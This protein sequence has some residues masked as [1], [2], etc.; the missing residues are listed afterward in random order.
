MDDTRIAGPRDQAALDPR[1]GATADAVVER[2]RHLG[3]EQI[4]A[5]DHAPEHQI[6]VEDATVGVQREALVGRLEQLLEPVAS[7]LGGW[8]WIPHLLP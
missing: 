3:P 1:A 8:Q 2:E 6:A 7:T 5:A 4:G